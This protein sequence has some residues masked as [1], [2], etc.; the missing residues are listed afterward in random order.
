[1]RHQPKWRAKFTGSSVT[2]P[3]ISSSEPATKEN[4][5]HPMSQ[6][7]AKAAV[8]KGKGKEG[9]SSQNESFFIVG[10]MLFTLKKLSILLAKA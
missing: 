9:S 7:R 2:D 1:V 5:T 4:V 6:N 10:V 8:R 3:Q